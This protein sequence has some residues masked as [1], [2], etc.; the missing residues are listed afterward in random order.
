MKS[1]RRVVMAVAMGASGVIAFAG[2]A[3]AHVSIYAAGTTGAAINADGSTTYQIA[4]A[5]GHGCAGPRTTANPDGAYVTT[6]L[7]VFMPKNDAGNFIL[8]DPKVI[9]S[10]DYTATIKRVVDPTNSAAYRTSSVVFSN[11]KMPAVNNGW[12]AKDTMMFQLAIKL[13]TLAAVKAANNIASGTAN[14]ATGA[15]V[16]FPTM[17]YCAVPGQGAGI[18][19]AGSTAAV[20]GATVDPACTAND[21]IVD[22]LDDN[23]TTVGNTPSLTIGTSN[24]AANV[25]TFS[26][27]APTAAATTSTFCHDAS[28]IDPSA[29]K[30]P[31]IV[32]TKFTSKSG[33]LKVAINAGGLYGSRNFTLKTVSGKIVVSGKLDDRGFCVK[34]LVNVTSKFGLKLTSQLRMFFGKTPIDVATLS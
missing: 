33:A 32:A 15:T 6:S 23:W 5:P 7:E 30:L 18:Q 14:T 34:T 29:Y 27:N 28:G 11:F 12:A 26:G 1:L 17:Q 31:G 9:D 2:T 21:T 24:L 4:F 19:G 3:Q 13:P 25:V 20:A 8:A 22:T 16:Y 10:K